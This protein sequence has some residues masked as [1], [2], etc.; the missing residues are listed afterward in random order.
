MQT[1]AKDGRLRRFSTQ[2]IV[3]QNLGRKTRSSMTFS[4]Q[5]LQGQHGT[6]FILVELTVNGVVQRQVL[7]CLASI[8]LRVTICVYDSDIAFAL[9][10]ISLVNTLLQL[11]KEVPFNTVFVG[12][13]ILPAERH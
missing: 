9:L 2:S 7:L 13:F 10:K 11:M 3:S 1:R 4:C 6:E 5:N 8:G 12:Q